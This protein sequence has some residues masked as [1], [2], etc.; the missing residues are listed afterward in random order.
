MNQHIAIVTTE[1]LP[2]TS[3]PCAGGGVRIW[4]L[5]EALRRE[6]IQC[7]YFILDTLK[8]AFHIR[9][10]PSISFYK[11]EFLDSQLSQSKY[12]AVL[13]EQW[14]PLTFLKQ[15]LDIP[16]IVDLPGPLLLEYYWRDQNRFYRH[17][18]DKVT[19]LSTADYFICA[20]DRQRAY[21]T[22]WLTLAGIPPDHERI[23][24]VPFV[25]HEMPRSR[26]G[27]TE[28]EAQLFWGGMF[29]PWQQRTGAF[30]T[31]LETITR[32]RRG[33]L[34]IAGDWHDSQGNSEHDIAYTENHPHVSWLG[35]L[36]FTDYASEL[37][38]AAVAIDLA[39]PTEERRISSDLRTGTALWACTP[40]IVTPD[41]PWAHMIETHNAGWII[42]YDDTKGLRHLIEEIVLERVDIVAK[43]RGAREI[44]NLISDTSQIRP[45]LNWLKNPSKRERSSP[46]FEAGIQD[47]NRQ[48]H[49]LQND[50]DQLQH[51][52]QHLQHDLDSIRSNPLFRAYKKLTGMFSS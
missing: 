5:G 14:Q 51:A 50:K 7:T 15:S 21:Y 26:Q 16:I 24:T 48:L 27:F 37:K 9:N 49:K 34:V 23:A 40:C 1:N 45:L 33:Q 44:S 32:L 4:G 41:S 19:T 30:N 47:L 39:K 35:K 42:K 46:F 6:G 18:M 43:R 11:P 2:C 3:L 8:E 38:R 17:L 31:I 12:E 22:A 20:L 29:W 52:N 36:G 13:F 10:A 28:D 25:F